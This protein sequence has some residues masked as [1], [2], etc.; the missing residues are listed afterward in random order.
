MRLFIYLAALLIPLAVGAQTAN[1]KKSNVPHQNYTVS[2]KQKLQRTQVSSNKNFRLSYTPSPD[3]IPVN[4][5]FRLKLFLQNKNNQIVTAAKLKIDATMPDHNHGMN[6][7]PKLKELGKGVYAVEGFL[8][9]MPGYWE[10]K[11]TINHAGKTETVVFGVNVELKPT[12]NK[13]QH[14]H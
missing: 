3:P 10:I 1:S 9:H 14:H 13:Q 7:K 11:A 4:Q 6:V 5:H 12:Q 2:N 8:F